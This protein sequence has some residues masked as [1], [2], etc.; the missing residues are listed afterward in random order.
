MSQVKSSLPLVLLVA[1]LALV[2]GYV[3]AQHKHKHKHDEP[4]KEMPQKLDFLFTEFLPDTLGR[5]QS[6]QASLKS[7]NIINY[8]ATWCAPCRH[9]MPVLQAF[10]EANHDKG[11]SVL[12]MTLDD[13]EP[14]ETFIQELGVRYPIF[15]MGDKGWELLSAS[16]NKRGLLPYTLLVD[17]GGNV[18]ESKLGEVTGKLLSKWVEKHLKTDNL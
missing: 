8:W 14:T 3:F 4:L 10:Y 6:I 5:E 15:I 7:L 16:G 11:V 13:P 12:G 9:E 17:S 18:L 1:V 2:L